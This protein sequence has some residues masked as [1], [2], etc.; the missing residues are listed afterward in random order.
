MERILLT[1]AVL[2]ASLA[3]G[4]AQTLQEILEKASEHITKSDD[5]RITIEENNDTF[6]P[7]GFTG[8]MRLEIRTWKNG[9]EDKESPMDIRMTFTDDRMAMAPQ[10]ARSKEQVR[11]IFDLAARHT[12]TLMTDAKGKRTGMKMK[13]MKV[14]LEGDG[15]EKDDTQVVRTDETRTIQGQPCRKYTYSDQEGHGEAWIAEGVDFD[16]MQAFARMSSGHG[17]QAWQQMHEG[18]LVMENTWEAA[19]GKERSAMKVLDLRIGTVDEELFSTSGF[20]VQD[21]TAFPVFGR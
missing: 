7:L 16:L 3:P 2:A 9:A 10:A 5:T 12:Y 15:A 17:L 11:M 1:I 20:D 13:M 19:N 8:S 18:G 4:H 6:T 21:M 14:H